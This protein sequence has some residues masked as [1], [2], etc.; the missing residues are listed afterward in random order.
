M[1]VRVFEALLGALLAIAGGYFAW[2]NRGSVDGMFP[3]EPGLSVWTFVGG[4]VAVIIGAVM[5]VHALGPRP[6]E[7]ARR[8]AEEE[9]RTRILQQ[10]ERFYTSKAEDLASL[11]TKEGDPLFPEGLRPGGT[12]PQ[13]MERRD[14]PSDTAPPEA[15]RLHSLSQPPP[16]SARPAERTEP[17]A[18]IPEPAAAAPANAA[19]DA[20]REPMRNGSAAPAT[21]AAVFAN[22]DTSAPAN[23]FPAKPPT[24][25]IPRAEEPPPANAQTSQQAAPAVPVV[26][27]AASTDAPSPEAAPAGD[28]ALEEIRTAIAQNRLEDADRLLAE[29]R[30]RMNDGGASDPAQ[31]AQL[32]GLAGDHAAADGR[33]GSAKWLWR[34]ALQRFAAAGAIDDPAARAV[35]ERMRLADQ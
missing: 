28:P 22:P 24:M 1:V 16:G 23:P 31:L 4:L 27:P 8:L 35:S 32:T 14:R 6:K 12:P 10:A 15:F 3:P 25:G 19:N 33:L 7:K 9:K 11:G 13:P 29:T 17:P 26:E 18:S 30:K 5:V 34:L 2:M 21:Q 20:S